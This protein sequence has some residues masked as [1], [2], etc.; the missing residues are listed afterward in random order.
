MVALK[1]KKECLLMALW[2]GVRVTAMVWVIE[3]QFTWPC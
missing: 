3:R 2:A 1:M